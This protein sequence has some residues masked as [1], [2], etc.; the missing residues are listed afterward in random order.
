MPN[1]HTTPVPSTFSFRVFQETKDSFG[2]RVEYQR[3]HYVRRIAFCT[4]SWPIAMPISTDRYSSGRPQAM[5]SIFRIRDVPSRCPCV[6]I[7]LGFEIAR[8]SFRLFV[9]RSRAV[10][11]ELILTHNGHGSV[12]ESSPVRWR[13]MRAMSWI[14]TNLQFCTHQLSVSSSSTL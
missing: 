1:D 13:D 5:D 14:A 11:I 12:Q 4:R 9:C 2:N 3:R 6:N 10:S 8:E 7:L